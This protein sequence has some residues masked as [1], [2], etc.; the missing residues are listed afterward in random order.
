VGAPLIGL[1]GFGIVAGLVLLGRGLSGYRRALQIEGFASSATRSVAVGEARVAGTIEAAEVTLISPLQ[2]EPCVYFRSSVDAGDGRSRRR[3]FSDERGVGFR[4]RDSSGAI[5]VFPR[6]ARWDVPDRWSGDDLFGG[7]PPGLLLR[8][9]P[10]TK[11]AVE[12]HDQA[13]AELLTVHEPGRLDDL[14]GLGG[15]GLG[16][17][18]PTGG[19][20]TYREARL[21][22]GDAITV[23]GMVLPYD[24]LPD[25]SAANEESG[26]AAFDETADPVVAADLAEA[27][28]S[29]GLAAD[30]AHAWGNAAIEGFGIDQPVRA[31]DLDPA[32]HRPELAPAGRAEAT[33]Q[34][35]DIAPETL[36]VA[37]TPTVPLLIAAGTPVGAES[38]NQGR[39]VLGLAGAALA[40]VS[41]VALA[42]AVTGATP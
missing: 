41:A 25:P 7:S 1:A 15:G 37:A 20:R 32:A 12:P 26:A 21:A 8:A 34:A 40:V 30:S 36:I 11:S 14:A 4:V 3:I 39:F 5:R 42:L 2:S 35:F 9:G 16:S 38:R 31:P 13:V 24:Q 18:L 33:H 10:A 22:V 19:R 27:R 6:G 23:I 29:G 28:A 17:D